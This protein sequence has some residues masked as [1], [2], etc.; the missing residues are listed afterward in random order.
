VA[1]WWCFPCKPKHVGAVLLILK[2]FNNSTS[3]NVVWISWK[4][5]C[6]ILLMHGV[7]MKFIALLSL[8]QCSPGHYNAAIIN[9]LHTVTK[10]FVGLFDDTRN[11]WGYVVLRTRIMN[12]GLGTMCRK[13]VVACF[14]RLSE[15]ERRKPRRTLTRVATLQ[16]E[17]L[18]RGSLNPNTNCWLL[19]NTII[20]CRCCCFPGVTP[21]C[22]CIFTAR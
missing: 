6:W 7:T 5:K 20:T 1:P 13:A 4:L 22:G 9:F 15:P 8:C 11:F 19:D 2:C 3:F 17:I 18:T 12:T 16:L 21:H 14:T 10:T